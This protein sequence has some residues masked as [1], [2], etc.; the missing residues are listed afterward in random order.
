MSAAA[1]FGMKSRYPGLTAAYPVAAER[2]ARG[3]A[4]LR[5]GFIL[6]RQPIAVQHPKA[7]GTELDRWW[8]ARAAVRSPVD[9]GQS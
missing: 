4:D 7:G 2:R 6:G 9:A 1:A 3:G 5:S 8:G